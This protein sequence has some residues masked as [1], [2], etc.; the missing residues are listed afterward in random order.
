[1]ALK[2][3][4]LVNER[5]LKENFRK[6]KVLGSRLDN[7]QI[8]V[9]VLSLWEIHLDQ[10]MSVNSPQTF[11]SPQPSRLG[12]TPP[13]TAFRGRATSERCPRCCQ[14]HFGPCSAPQVCFQCG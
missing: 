6:E 8:K 9:K 14:S 4:K 7:P 13:S 5:G 11:R 1:M 12:A 2:A 3:E 10:V